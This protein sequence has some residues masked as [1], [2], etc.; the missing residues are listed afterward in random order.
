MAFEH[1]AESCRASAGFSAVQ[2]KDQWR[3][4]RQSETPTVEIRK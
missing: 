3:Y 1:A 4:R 2:G